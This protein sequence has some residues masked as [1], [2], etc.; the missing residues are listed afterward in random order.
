MSTINTIQISEYT[1]PNDFVEVAKAAGMKIVAISGYAPYS[2]AFVPDWEHRGEV[3]IVDGHKPNEVEVAL[4]PGE[5]S[6]TLPQS[7]VKALI[8]WVPNEGNP[9]LARLVNGISQMLD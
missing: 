7:D 5:K 2:V 9:D 8:S 6:I 4:Q 3:V 1:D